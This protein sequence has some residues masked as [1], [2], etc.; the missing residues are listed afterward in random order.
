MR[1]SYVLSSG[2]KISV[3][4][5]VNL[6][7]NFPI[8][9][10]QYGSSSPYNTAGN[11]WGISAGSEPETKVMVNAIKTLKPKFHID[12]HDW[13]APLTAASGNKTLVLK[14]NQ[15]QNNYFAS[16]KPKYNGKL[17]AP[18]PLQYYGGLA[19]GTFACES[20]GLGI[21]CTSMLVELDPATDSQFRTG[22]YTACPT[23]AIQQYYYPKVKGLLLGT[24]DNTA[25][26]I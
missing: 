24:L 17:L 21:G 2:V 10:G 18:Y 6:N 7:R 19:G 13:G 16:V 1:R 4:Y 5:G 9:W 11:Y 20:Q 12:F 15:T 25:I 26:K 8:G 22:T 14:V 23:W 3:P